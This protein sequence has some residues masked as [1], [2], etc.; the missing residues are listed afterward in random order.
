MRWLGGIVLMVA[1]AATACRQPPEPKQYE[2]RGQIL[3]FDPQRNEVVVDHEDIEGFMPAMVMPYKVQDPS[4]L[5]G[6]KP[7]DMVTATL[8]VEEVNAYLTTLTTTGHEPIRTPAAG[9]LITDADILKDGDLVPD[10]ALVDQ[11]D[12]P[13]P[14][15]SLRGHR[16][17]LTFMYSRCPLP[18]FCPLMDKHFASV[19]EQIKASSDLADVRLVSVTI[20]PAFD[21]PAVLA[22]HAKTLGADPARWHFATGQADDVLAFAKRFGVIAEPG[23]TAVELV[24]NLRTAIIDSQGR[25][26]K[27]YSGNMWSPAELVADLKATPPPTR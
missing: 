10:H 25:L 24:H 8:V 14:M 27:A 16:V 26:V 5:E 12:K 17:A 3:S 4:L 21:T 22:R 19:Q 9:P 20:D 23:A 18:D 2:V 6:K 7:G 15:Q 13:L 1:V 11:S